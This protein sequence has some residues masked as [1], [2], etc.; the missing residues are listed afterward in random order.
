MKEFNFPKQSQ[1]QKT[2]RSGETYIEWFVTSVLGWIYRPV[3]NES[4]FGIDGFVDIVTDDCVTG[5]GLALQIKCGNSYISK[6]T[7]GGIKYEGSNQHL[8]YYLNHSVPIV[9]IVLDSDCS[10]GYWV[11][12][13]IN[14]TTPKKTGWWIEIPIKNK[15]DQNVSEHWA[16]I[17]GSVEDYSEEIKMLW[18]IDEFV[19]STNYRSFAIP[20]QEISQCSMEYISNLISRLSKTKEQTLANRGKLEVF[21]PG[22]DSDPREIYE[23]PEIRKWFN[24]SIDH[25]IPW[26][27]FLDTRGHGISIKLLLFC[28]CNVTLQEIQG[29]RLVLN[30]NPEERAKWLMRN[31]EN[32]NVFTEAHGIPL[33]INKERCD[34]V[35]KCL[36]KSTANN[37]S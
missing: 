4:D 37:D 15:L 18:Q 2:G 8:N 26:F 19:A 23:I 11:D 24:A 1:S 13:D 31:Y 21:F 3:H 22:Y 12:F 29:N 6:V 32:L 9:L 14:K 5:R 34:A 36:E 35:M 7:D 17:A 33:T 10:K 16:S 20:L 28:T 25:G 30:T 27:Y